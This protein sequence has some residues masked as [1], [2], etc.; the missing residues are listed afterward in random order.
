MPLEQ[1]RRAG[2]PETSRALAFTALYERGKVESAF[3]WSDTGVAGGENQ[4]EDKNK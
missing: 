4:G 1:V 3:L 2:S